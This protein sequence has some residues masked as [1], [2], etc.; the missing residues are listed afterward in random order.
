V[1][2]NVALPVELGGGGGHDALSV[3]RA[4]EMVGLGPFARAFP[5][6]LSGGMRMRVSIAR[7]LITRPGLLLM[8][9]PFGALDAIT[10]QRLNE[11]LLRLW[12]QDR[13]TCLFVTHSVHEAVF[14]SQRVLVMSARPG[15]LLAD[16]EVPF[17]YPRT[18]GLFTT[19]EFNQLAGQIAG[20]LQPTLS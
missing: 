18:A 8:D 15:R 6:Q 17:P 10:R 1:A 4:L 9:E 16:L 3:D 12:E 5:A 14:L 13:W 20:R 19:T 7:A 11:E 2:R